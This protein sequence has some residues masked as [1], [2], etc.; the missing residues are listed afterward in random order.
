VAASIV[1]DRP[2]GPLVQSSFTLPDRLMAVLLK[3]PGG[4]CDPD[5]SRLVTLTVPFRDTAATA[6]PPPLAEAPSALAQA[7]ARKPEGPGEMS[8]GGLTTP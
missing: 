5:A 7:R 4:L 2:V 6:P 1:A 8:G 3:K